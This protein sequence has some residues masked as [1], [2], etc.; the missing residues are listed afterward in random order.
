MELNWWI[1]VWLKHERF[2]DKTPR[3]QRTVPEVSEIHGSLDETGRSRV[4]FSEYGQRDPHLPCVRPQGSR[5]DP[6]L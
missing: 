6:A 4:Q 3:A 5:T 2:N 1:W